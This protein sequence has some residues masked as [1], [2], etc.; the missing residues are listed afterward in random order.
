RRAA[1][2]AQPGRPDARPG[3]SRCRPRASLRHPDG[4]AVRWPRSRTAGGDAMTGAVGKAIRAAV[5]RRRLQTL[6]IGTVVLLSTAT[7]V[8]ALGLI[9]ASDA[10]F[11]HAFSRQSGAHVTASFDAGL[12]TGAAL[13][14]T[15][16]RPGVIA[17]AGPFDSV[18]LRLTAGGIGLGSVTVVGRADADGP[19]DRLTLDSGQW[20]TGSGQIVLSRELAGPRG[21]GIGDSVTVDVP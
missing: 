14:A 16:A 6:V 13:A 2:G 10:P 20:L 17:A 5:R 19:V 11:D 7:A 18:D 21:T 9:V 4:R 12:V 3:H 8:L 15:A 1:Q